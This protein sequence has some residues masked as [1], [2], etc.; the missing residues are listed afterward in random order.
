MDGFGLFVLIFIGFVVL[1]L[2]LGV[3]TVPQGQEYTIERWGRFTRS[4]KTSSSA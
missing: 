1:M 4:V 3:K 2:A